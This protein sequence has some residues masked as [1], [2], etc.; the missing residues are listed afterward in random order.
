MNPTG[1]YEEYAFVAPFY[2]HVV[3]YRN[4]PDVAFFV[5]AATKSNGRVLEIGCGTGRVLIPTARSGVE[6][7]GLDLSA[8]MLAVCRE[9]LHQEE[10][11][12]RS[13]VELI[14]ADMFAAGLRFLH[15]N[16]P[17][18]PLI[19][20][21]WRQRFPS[22]QG[23]GI[24]QERLSQ[25]SRQI[26]YDATGNLLS[27]R[28]VLQSQKSRFA[29]RR[30]ATRA[31]CERV[32]TIHEQVIHPVANSVR[33]DQELECLLRAGSCRGQQREHQGNENNDGQGPRR[34]PKP[35]MQA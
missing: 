23:S 30:S 33:R 5:D 8:R 2:D 26:M 22:R 35:R 32:A 34:R 3:P 1:G 4:R 7:V 24:R 11:E 10:E 13:R 21:E 6:I 15:G 20:R 18:N 27:H 29:V 28:L 31:V 25:I 16:H 19:A 9:R 12:V 14:E 17:A